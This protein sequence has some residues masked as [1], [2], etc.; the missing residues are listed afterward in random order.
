MSSFLEQINA[1]AAA[2]KQHIVLPEGGD[3]RTLNAARALVDGNIAE[4]T[5]L[6]DPQK[7]AESG[8][9]LSGI[10]IVNPAQSPSNARYAEVLFELRKAKGL[11]LEDAQKLVQQE[12]YHGV[13]M[14]YLDEAD[15]MVAGAVHSTSNVLRPCLQILKTAP[16]VALVSAFFVIVVPD[17]DFGANGTFIFADSGL[18]QHPTA[19]ELAEIAL[20]SAGSFES[21]VE[22]TPVVAMLSHST[23]GSAKSPSVAKVELATQLARA[24][25]PQLALD[26]ELQLDAAIVPSVG[27][28]KAP[29]STVAGHANVLVFPD[30]DSGNIAYKLAQRLA[31]AEAYGPI[32]QGLAK[33]VNDLSR[34]ASAEDIAGVVA[35]TAVQSQ[36]RKNQ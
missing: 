26:G 2:N 30:L 4:I 22:A 18:V 36:A 19:E 3:L 14:V 24:K 20:S 10:N 6:A 1:R 29:D 23:K 5:V 9:D 8:I 15:G 27:E 13:M 17:C 34:G 16:G 31:R 21:L 7:A 25:A 33:P 32:T 11:T 12:L 28:S 35:I